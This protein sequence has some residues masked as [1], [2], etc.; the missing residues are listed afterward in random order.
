MVKPP[1]FQG[2]VDMQE[3]QWLLEIKEQ[4]SN[5]QWPTECRR[6][7]DT[8]KIDGTSIRTHSLRRHSMFFP[9]E[10]NYLILG[11]VLDNVCNSACQ[12]CNPGLS[13]KIGSLHGR[14]AYKIVDN[15]S[16]LDRI[17]MDRVVEIDLNGGEPTASPRY[18]KMLEHMGKNVRVL[19]VN[20]N[21]S[22]VLPNIEQILSNGTQVIIT[23]SLDGTDK[24]HDY[25]RWP[26]KWSQY[27]KTVE[28]YN[29]LR[30]R[31]RNLKLQAWTVVHALNAQDIPNIKQFCVDHELDHSWAFLEQPAELDARASNSMTRAT[32]AKL[33]QQVDEVSLNIAK[34]IAQGPDNQSKFDAYVSTQDSL[35]SIR[36]EDYL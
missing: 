27:T 16:L 18:Q 7:R 4:M 13:T 33:T 17:P 5:D 15:S 21:G 8:E 6:C 12:S 14:D 19:R 3:S 11:G 1:T 34:D 36:M 9:L 28:Q 22:R 23:L 26:I 35:R 32:R 2:F 10:P 25:V 20:T 30:R 24:V 31:F 29:N